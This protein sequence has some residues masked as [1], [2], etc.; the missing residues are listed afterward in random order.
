L[1]GPVYLIDQNNIAENRSGFELKSPFSGIKNEVPN[2]SEG[3]RSGVN[4]ILEKFTSMIFASSF[5]LSV[6]A[7]PAHLL[8]KYG[9]R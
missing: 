5:A 8:S 2:T 9:H 6:F 1:Q 3:I 4:C 7:T